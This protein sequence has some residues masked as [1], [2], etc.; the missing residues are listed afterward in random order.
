VAVLGVSSTAGRLLIGRAA[1]TLSKIDIMQVSMAVSGVCVVGMAVLPPKEVVLIFIALLFGFFAGSV[2]T[3]FTC[4]A[5]TEK[6]N[7]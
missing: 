3:Q 4:F 5:S 6:D 2:G 1:Q 7:H